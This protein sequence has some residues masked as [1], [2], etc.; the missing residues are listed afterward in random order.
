MIKTRVEALNVL[1]L[2]ANAD[3]AEI[4]MAYRDLAKIYHPDA[5]NGGN[6]TIFNRINEAY[7]F[8]MNEVSVTIPSFNVTPLP[9]TKKPKTTASN[10]DYAAWEKKVKKQ[11]EQKLKDMEEKAAK[12]SE[13]K[14]TQDEQYKKAMEAIDA[15]R[16][17]NAIEAMVRANAMEK[18]EQE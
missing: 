13:E 18:D 9:R 7:D 11:R 16:V 6:I 8:A 17:A 15:I 14:R 5:E 3:E 4:K 2:P 1:G 10:S 12:L